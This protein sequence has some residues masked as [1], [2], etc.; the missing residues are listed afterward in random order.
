MS[1]SFFVVPAIVVSLG[2]ILGVIYPYR[3]RG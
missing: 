3:L 1:L 2:S